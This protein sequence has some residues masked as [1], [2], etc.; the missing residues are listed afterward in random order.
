MAEAT[1]RPQDVTPTGERLPDWPET[2]ASSGGELGTMPPTGSESYRPLSLLALAAFGTSVVYALIVLIGGAVALFNHIPCL[3]PS[4]TFLLP[5]AI[6]VLC[7]VARNR[8]RNGEGTL[9][10]LAFTT[11]GIRLTVV[12]GLTYLAYYGFTFFAVRLQAQDYA[13]EFF[14]EL[15]QGHTERAFLLATGTSPQGINEA[16]LRDKIEILFN[17]PNGPAGTTGSYTQ[18]CQS[19]F[20]RSIEMSGKEASV[21][22]KGVMEWG[23]G[24]GGYRVV[25]KYQVAT[26]LVELEMKVE[27]FGRDSKPGES[28]GRQW[29]L[30]IQKGETG[31]LPSS[32]KLTDRGEDFL[33]KAAAAQS[34]AINWQEKINRGQW[35]EVYL[36]T[37]EPAERERLRKDRK[38]A[39]LLPMAPLVGLA[40]LGMCDEGC[41]DLLN[42]RQKLAEGKLIRLD[43][44]KLWTSKRDRD[45]ILK[46]LQQTFRPG[47]AGESLFMIRPQ[48]TLMPLSRSHDGRLAFLFDTQLTYRDEEILTQKY[49]VEAYIAVSA[50]DGERAVTPSTWRVEAIEVSSARTPPVMPGKPG[51]PGGGP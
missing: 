35:E 33:Q 27:A 15:Q 13:D 28:R 24:K 9:T 40:P 12:V 7:W 46:R 43:D 3:M 47:S 1:D 37:L 41:L 39:D 31:V 32:I 36:D 19:Q 45:A 6:L 34:F 11:W 38:T 20:V 17:S 44:K 14:K 2:L 25:M 26:P 10:G 48:P 30:L 18:F 5:I 16:D 21:T 42:A 50:E 49:V 23:Y 51:Q 29:E 22:P 8:I 4:W